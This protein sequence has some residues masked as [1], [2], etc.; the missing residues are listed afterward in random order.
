M[1][2]EGYNSKKFILT[3]VS[4]VGYLAYCFLN[5]VTP[6]PVGLTALIGTYGALNVAN[7][8]VTGNAP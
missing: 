2:K 7:K 8:K 3:A 1:E 6:E 5:H 4:I